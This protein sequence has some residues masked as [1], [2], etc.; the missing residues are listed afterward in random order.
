MLKKFL[1]GIGIL[2]MITGI[3]ACKSEETESN[4]VV[5]GP[6]SQELASLF[7]NEEGSKWEYYGTSDYG[8]QMVID[9]IYEAN[10]Q[11][12]LKVVGEVADPSGSAS[13]NN[14]SLEITYGIESDRVIQTKLSDEMMDSEYD[15]LTLIMSPLAIGTKWRENTVDSQG[16]S[17]AVE[18]EI[19]SIDES[20][21]G[22]IYKV[23]YKEV[24]SDY[25]EVR[26]IQTGKGVVEFVKTLKYDDQSLEFAYH[27]YKL[28]APDQLISNVL[29]ESEVNR[30][31]GVIFKFDELWIDFVNQ[32]DIGLMN[33]VVPESPVAEMINQYKR[34]DSKQKYLSIEVEDVKVT[35]NVAL[36]KVYE[37]MQQIKGEDVEIFEYHWQY[38]MEKTGEQWYIHSYIED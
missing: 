36:V 1:L 5:A 18:S 21:D 29:D 22:Q 20:S 26:K 13:N 33:Y 3:S 30:I 12:V 15:H 6:Y 2:L 17:V 23:I 11:K 4:I 16:K 10:S 24:K 19:I 27:L 14:Y 9:K 8:H 37:K 38:R 34:D 25:S 32:G 35:G 31:K 7:P 28:S